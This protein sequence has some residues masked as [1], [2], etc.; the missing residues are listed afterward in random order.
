MYWVRKERMDSAYRQMGQTIFG[1]VLTTLLSGLFLA[2][3]E[4]ESLY[5]FGIL[6]ITT[7]A[8]ASIIALILLP[9]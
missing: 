3:C 9:S 7:I 8:S 2:I 1:G 6:L 4:T 5:K